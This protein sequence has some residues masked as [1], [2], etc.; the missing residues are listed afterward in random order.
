MAVDYWQVPRLHGAELE[1]RKNPERLA[2]I[3]LLAALFSCVGLAVAIPL[4]IRHYILYSRVEQSVL[5]EVHRGPLRVTLAGRGQPEA[6][7]EDR[8]EI[9]RRTVVATDS[10]AGRI[11][12]HARGDGESIVA[13]AQLY[14]NTEVVLLSAQSPRFAVSGLAHQI[15][16]E[17]RAGRVRIN[18]SSDEARPTSVEVRTPVGIGRLA[19]GRY[20]VRIIDATAQITVIDGQAEVVHGTGAVASLGTAER[21]IMDSDRI[22]GPLPAARNLIANGDFAAPV[23]DE[24]VPYNVGIEFEGQPLGRVKRTEIDGRSVAVIE[25]TGIGHAETGITQRLDA[26][27][28]DF[29]SLRLH[30]LLRIEDHNVPVCGSLGSECPLMIKI[31]YEDATGADQEWLQGFYLHPDPNTPGNQPFCVVCTV[32]YEHLRVPDDTW[33]TFDSD[34]LIPLLSRNGN[35]PTMIKSMTVYASGHAYR[36]AIAEIDLIGQ[37]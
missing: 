10:T 27:V 1:M 15:V 6:A 3:V 16:L 7:S 36:S 21:A 11:V 5:L 30:V 24:W 26:D 28:R 35:V 34:S 37:E 18:V 14:D 19:E 31:A 25:R 33:Y 17:V 23:G 20:E 8:T 2:W 32:P 22:V 13:T 29:S 4:G 9:P 12:M